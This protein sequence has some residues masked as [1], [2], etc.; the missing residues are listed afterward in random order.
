MGA[1][2]KRLRGFWRDTRAA[3]ATTIALLA[4]VLIGSTGFVI[5]IG[6]VA[7]VQQQL[8]AAT[9]SAAL[10]GGYQIP[11]NH[12]VSTATTYASTNAP[13]GITAT[14]VTGFPKLKC[15]TSTGVTCAGTELTGGANAIQVSESATVP[16]WFAQILG[17]SSF[18]VTAT[19]TAGARG[20]VGEALNVEIVLDTTAS[21]SSNT[22]NNCGLGA[23]ATREACALNGVKTL[24]TNL[25]PN[26]D[27]VGIVV[28]PGL[29][30]STQA[31]QEY[32]CGGSLSSSN[33]Q[34]YGNSPIY[35]IVPL[36]ND[37][38]TS[39]TSTTLNASSHLALAVNDGGCTSGVSAPGG[40][41]TYYA[42]AINAAQAALVALSSSQTPPA[43]NVIVILSDGDAYSSSVETDFTGY[44]GGTCTVSRGHT[45]CTNSTT[46]TV[47]TC[48]NSCAAST[49][50]NQ[51]GPLAAGM[52]I[53]G[54]GVSSG[55]TIVKQLSGTTGGAGTY[56]VSISQ[57]AGAHSAISLT[58]AASVTMN[59]LTF[60]QNVN[61]CQQAIA[62]SQAAAHA[63]TWVYSVA[64]GASTSTGCATDTS[65]IITGMSGLSSCTA[66]Q[67]L[68]NTPGIYPDT[69]KFYS[70]NN[71]GQDCPHSNTIEDLTD[72]FTNL[73]TNLTEP[74]LLPND[75]T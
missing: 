36:G 43:Q 42:Q 6:H 30:S 12:G 31:S 38:K 60:T 73:S 35:A 26:L 25:N 67:Y 46:M 70:N 50:R 20:G 19:S 65:A 28:F 61:Q 3:S 74:R 39:S 22:D 64:Y 53:T 34:T 52:V 27:H 17:L 24:L 11:S 66:M 23:H 32:T 68:A 41:G 4:P 18:S 9:D 55:T 40:Q 33:T 59:S 57:N 56:Q 10:A 72:L 29:Q 71:N 14:M 49:S 54:T 7:V 5:D 21:M 13:A 51:Q 2:L 47:S 8:Q 1:F 62:A 44:I 69:S 63:G 45:T 48:P 37:F 15:F 16:L 58:G 75:T